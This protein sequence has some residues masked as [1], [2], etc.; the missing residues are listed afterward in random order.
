M[1]SFTTTHPTNSQCFTAASSSRPI[2]SSLF[3]AP[4]SNPTTL[5]QPFPSWHNHLQATAAAH[6]VGGTHNTNSW[7]GNPAV[8]SSNPWPAVSSSNSVPVSSVFVSRPSADGAT[9]SNPWFGAS[10]SNSAPVSNPWFGNPLAGQPQPSNPWIG[11]Q[12]PAHIPHLNPAYTPFNPVPPCNPS[13]HSLPVSKWTISK[14][15]GEDQGLKLNQFLGMVHTMAVAKG[16]VTQHTVLVPIFFSVFDRR[17]DGLLKVPGA[18][19]CF[20][21]VSKYVFRQPCF[22]ASSQLFSLTFRCYFCITN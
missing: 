5:S 8:G 14:Y 2:P 15:D 13:R 19:Q 17:A 22:S 9:S 7:F 3:S 10:A 16:L 21:L 18:R 20:S 4:Q 12:T 11:T 1:S 6:S